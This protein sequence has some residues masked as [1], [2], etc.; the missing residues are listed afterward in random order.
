MSNVMEIQAAVTANFLLMSEES[1]TGRVLDVGCGAKPY[2]RMFPE[3]EWTGLDARPV[4]EVTADMDL[5]YDL[6]PEF[7]TVLCTDAL[8]FSRD[9]KRAVGNMAYALKSGGHLIITAPNC[10]EDDDSRWRFTLGGLGELVHLAGL[11]LIYIGDGRAEGFGG[12]FQALGND[13]KNSFEYRAEVPANF[14]GWTAAMDSKY[15]MLSC[16]IARKP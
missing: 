3:C 9:P 5:D 16:V 7:D 12:L 6:E 15:P 14:D 2:K 8:Q 11:E 10:A 4:G 13:L 1:I